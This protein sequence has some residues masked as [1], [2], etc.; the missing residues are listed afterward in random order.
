MGTGSEPA[1]ANPV[2]TASGEVP[3]PIFSQPRRANRSPTEPKSTA[4]AKKA[5][6]YL[7]HIAAIILPILSC[8]DKCF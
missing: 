6:S 7:P 1:H 3:V 5:R 2:K 4:R 8:D